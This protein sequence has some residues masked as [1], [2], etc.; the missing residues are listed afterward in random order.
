MHTPSLPA[1]ARLQPHVPFSTCPQEI[2]ELLLRS[3]ANSGHVDNFGFTALYE[4]ARMG[5]DDIIHLLMD[6]KAP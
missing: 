6:Y 2:V 5:H 3:G 1:Q 4:A